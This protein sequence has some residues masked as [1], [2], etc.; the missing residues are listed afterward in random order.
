MS[1]LSGEATDAL[2]VDIAYVL[3]RIPA[4]TLHELT[5]LP[6]ERCNALT[7]LFGG[8]VEGSAKPRKIPFPKSSVD[9][10]RKGRVRPR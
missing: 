3:A 9:A 6:I 10:P 8:V 4:N 5:G 7:S 1:S 2:I